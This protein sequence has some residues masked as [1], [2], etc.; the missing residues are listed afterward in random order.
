MPLAGACAGGTEVDEVYGPVGRLSRALGRV[1]LRNLKLRMSSV[2]R[3]LLAMG[4]VYDLSMG[5]G[6][7]R[8][9]GRGQR[10]RGTCLVRSGL[11]RRNAAG[12]LM[13][14]LNGRCGTLACQAMGDLQTTLQSR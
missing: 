11:K 9:G 8:E 12:S 14:A 13:R 6:G 3:E 2:R 5:G 1:D 7:E 4:S 10:M